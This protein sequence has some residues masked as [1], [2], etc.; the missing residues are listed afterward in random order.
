MKVLVTGAGALMGQGIIRSLRASLKQARIIAADPDPRATGLYWADAAYL[1]PNA[2]S[3][4]YAGALRRLLES[5][6]PDAILIGTDVELPFFAA[7]REVLENDFSLSVLVSNPEVI[8]VADD[9]WRTYGFLKANG[10]PYPNSSISLSDQEF[11]EDVRYPLVVKPRSGARSV[12][13]SVVTNRQE[14]ETAFMNLET[15]IVQEL[16]GSAESEYTAGAL[17]FDGECK[18][19]I[20]MRR[21]LRDGNTYRGFVES[22]PELNV[23][24]KALAERLCPHGPV[25]F[26]FRICDDLVK[27][28]EINAR[29]SGTTPLRAQAGFNEVEM[30]LRYL[31]EGKEIRQPPVRPLVLLR[32]WE[33]TCVE[34]AQFEEMSRRSVLNL[35]NA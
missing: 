28:F 1:I 32:H 11:F 5:E 13:M 6:R 18:A 4:E 3:P 9:K 23:K 33:E 24:V 27:V 16:V 21:D 8:E 20:V 34:W 35:V 30:C 31:L 29:F 2:H 19:S 14:L 26:Q 10:F 7:Q 22:Y 25:N 17:V 12:G 15:P